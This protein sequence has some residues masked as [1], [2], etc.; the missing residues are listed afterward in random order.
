MVSL[1]LG[2]NFR[3]NDTGKE[4]GGDLAGILREVG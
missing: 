3:N 2:R 4:K 1:Y